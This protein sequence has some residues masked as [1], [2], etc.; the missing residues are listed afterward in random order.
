MDELHARAQREVG[1]SLMPGLFDHWLPMT[2][3]LVAS[4]TRLAEALNTTHPHQVRWAAGTKPADSRYSSQGA[5]F[6]QPVCS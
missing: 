3:D 4:L 1:S 6:M 2:D 5:W